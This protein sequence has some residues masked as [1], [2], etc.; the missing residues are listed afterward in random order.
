MEWTIES[1]TRDA[2]RHLKGVIPTAQFE[3]DDRLRRLVLLAMA[4]FACKTMANHLKD[5]LA[6]TAA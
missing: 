1:L 4:S 6:R 5:E 3:G 2:E